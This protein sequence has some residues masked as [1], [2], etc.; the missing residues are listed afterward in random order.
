VL[1]ARYTPERVQLE[2]TDEGDGGVGSHDRHLTVIGYTGWTEKTSDDKHNKGGT[3]GGKQ[4]KLPSAD[5]VD[6]E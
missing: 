6:D 4:E 1:S 2:R 5:S 3:C